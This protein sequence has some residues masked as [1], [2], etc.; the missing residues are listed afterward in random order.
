MS[1]SGVRHAV[2][3][4]VC[5]RLCVRRQHAESGAAELS[6]SEREGG[7]RFAGAG[8]REASQGT[9]HD[10][11]LSLCSDCQQ[12]Q[13]AVPQTLPVCSEGRDPNERYCQQQCYMLTSVV[14]SL[15]DVCLFRLT[16]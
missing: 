11:A 12:V 14:V 1:C 15:Y 16:C 13:L 6:S 4:C 5:V 8:G 9:A 10:S 3:V 7:R 2:D